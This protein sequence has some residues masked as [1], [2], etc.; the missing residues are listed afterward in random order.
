MKLF[1][2]LLPAL[3]ALAALSSCL[4]AGAQEAVIRKNLAEREPQ[5]PK[6]DEISKTPMPGLYELRV[7]GSDILY[8]DAS[9]NFLIQGSL[10]DTRARRNLTEE[11]IA[12]LTAV[13]FVKLPVADAFTIVRGNGKRQMAVFEDPNCPYCK[14]FERDLQG[15][16]NVTIHMF[17][18]PILGHDSPEKSRNVWCAKD[19]AKAWQ[20]L[21]VRDIAPPAASCDTSAIA[22]NLA[23]AQEH[24]ITGTPTLFFA[25]GARVPGYIDTQQVEK[26]LASAK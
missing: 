23:F 13:D 16:D 9:G 7:N 17:L 8:T 25:N 14:H 24:A 3:L 18:I 26:L 2:T 5:M 1:R 15:V 12:K 21:M 19:R 22:R 10:I 11:R 4:G 20:D 6:I